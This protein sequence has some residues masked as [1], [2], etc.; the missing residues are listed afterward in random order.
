MPELQ[1]SISK[2]FQQNN[3]ITYSDTVT[4]LKPVKGGSI[5]T[6]YMAATT[7]S[8]YQQLFVKLVNGD[9]GAEMFAAEKAGL[10]AL[11]QTQ[12]IRV[13][14][15]ISVGKLANGTAILVAEY[16]ELGPTKNMKLL[17][18]KLADLHLVRG[19]E[20]FGLDQDN[21]IGS[22]P[23]LNKWQASWVKFLNTRLVYQFTSSGLDIS[24]EIY[25]MCEDLLEQLPGYFE[26]IEIVPSLLH[27]DL[28]NGNCAEDQNG[29]PVIFDPAVYW[30]H[31]EAE[32]SIMRMF[33]GFSPEFFE[34]YHAKIP[35]APG[36]EKRALIYELYHAVNHYNTFGSRFLPTCKKLLGDILIT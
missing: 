13:P 9:S 15:F 10:Q 26:G 8:D 20:R 3:I 31:H 19:P 12:T 25:P 27:G 21:W 32:L 35:K 24:T 28:W 11:L 4:H 14:K 23:Q 16:I 29:Q 17:G 18:E 1:K 33:G 30:G 22:T 2:Y 34:A 7:N 6:A 36:F 5:C